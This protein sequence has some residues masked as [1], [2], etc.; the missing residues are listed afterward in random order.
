[1]LLFRIAK[2][3]KVFNQYESGFTLLETLVATAILGMVAAS[4][5]SGLAIG[6]KS[7]FIISKLSTAESLASSQMEQIKGSSYIDYA[8]P[9]HGDY[10]L[11]T[12]P[13]N[14]TIEVTC[15]PIS[16]S[17][18]D[19]LAPDQDEGIQKITVSVNHLGEQVIT[20]GS[21]KVSR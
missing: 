20:L 1:M 13:T 18:G 2:R 3:L 11:I 16:P 21:Y 9:G 4:L 5:L 7:D 17:T 14:Y 12:A 10:A 8:V 6:A 15:S 19:P